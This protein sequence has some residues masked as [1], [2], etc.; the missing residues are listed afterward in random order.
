[1]GGTSRG[2]IKEEFIRGGERLQFNVG[3]RHSV[4]NVNQRRTTQCK[5]A[6]FCCATVRVVTLLLD[7]CIAVTPAV[8][9]PLYSLEDCPF[10]YQV[11]QALRVGQRV[12]GTCTGRCADVSRT[13]VAPAHPSRKRKHC[14]A[15]G[16][17]TTSRLFPSC[18]DYTLL[19]RV[20]SCV[21]SAIHPRTRELLQGSILTV[22]L[23]R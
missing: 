1:M 21:S 11:P 7:V 6:Q 5:V 16:Q 19:L 3:Q 8:Q 12:T 17:L 15:A 14:F 2:K 18:N 9:T 20:S 13:H 4:H 23:A 10:V 22:D